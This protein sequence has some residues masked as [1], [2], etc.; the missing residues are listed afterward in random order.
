MWQLSKAFFDLCLLRLAPQQLPTS[1]FLV[2]LLMLVSVLMELLVQYPQSSPQQSLMLGMVSVTSTL[3]IIW[4]LLMMLKYSDRVVQTLTAVF[5]SDIVISFLAWPVM[6]AW[7]SEIE[8]KTAGVGTVIIPFIMI[9]RI[10][11]LAHIFRHAL[12][13][14]MLTAVAVAIAYSI[15]YIFILNIFFP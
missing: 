5:G 9:W 14:M 11:V 13:V 6:I 10:V 15:L 3:L 2:V 8:S 4:L 1:R 7:V 12:S